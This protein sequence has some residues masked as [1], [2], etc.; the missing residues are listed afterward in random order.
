MGGVGRI[1]RGAF[2]ARRRAAFLR[3]LEEAGNV[4]LAAEAAGVPKGRVYHARRRDAAFGAAWDAA[5]TAAQARLATEGGDLGATV[6]RRNCRGRL[7]RRIA[8]VGDWTDEDDARFLAA[9]IEHGCVTAAAKAAGKHAANA[10]R[11]RWGHAAFA[12]AWDEAIDEAEKGLHWSLIARAKAGL[13]GMVADPPPAGAKAPE[14]ELALA[15]L[16]LRGDRREGAR[17]AG[18]R[19]PRERDLAQVRDSVLAKLSAIERHRRGG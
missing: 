12:A 18:G 1:A 14:A 5:L 13:A 19:P 16:K 10:Y 8:R 2:T 9:L 11:R 6:V 3:A 15:L 7:G 17:R 4:T